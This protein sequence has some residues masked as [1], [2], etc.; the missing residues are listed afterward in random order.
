MSAQALAM[1]HAL[2]KDQVIPDVFSDSS[3]LELEG[4]LQIVYPDHAVTPAARIPR[5]ATLQQPSVKFNK[6]NDQEGT[7]EGLYTL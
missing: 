1:I 2:E 6:F 4:E 7:D 3:F 5:S